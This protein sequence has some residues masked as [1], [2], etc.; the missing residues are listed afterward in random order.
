[1]SGDDPEADHRPA[2]NAGPAA[3]PGASLEV[4]DQGQRRKGR[5]QNQ[6]KGL[7]KTV[8]RAVLVG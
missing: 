2:I 7:E 4:I 8:P 5:G 6:R 3:D 1:M